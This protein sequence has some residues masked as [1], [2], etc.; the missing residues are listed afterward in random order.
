MD[1]D[2][3]TTVS[4]PEEVHTP[5]SAGLG[6]FEFHFDEKPVKGP[7]GPHLFRPSPELQIRFDQDDCV[8]L[9]MAPS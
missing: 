2:S 3:H 7:S 9:S 6:D 1:G 5:H 4:T 8:D